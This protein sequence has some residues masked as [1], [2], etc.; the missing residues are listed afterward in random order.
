MSHGFT[1]DFKQW[2]E[3]F[4]VNVQNVPPDWRVFSK[5]KNKS[6][7]KQAVTDLHGRD[8][9]DFSFEDRPEDFIKIEPLNQAT[10]LP[11]FKIQDKLPSFDG[12]ILYG[13][14]F[15]VPEEEI[16]QALKKR[17]SE[18][19]KELKEVTAALKVAN[20]RAT[21][22][23]QKV[24]D[25][26]DKEY[27]R[28]IEKGLFDDKLFEYLFDSVN[29]KLESMGLLKRKTDGTLNRIGQKRLRTYISSR[30]D[31]AQSVGSLRKRKAQLQEELDETTESI[32]YKR[33]FAGVIEKAF[34]KK[35]KYPNHPHDITLQEWLIELSVDNYLR[36]RPSFPY[37]YVVYPESGS[38]F[39]TKLG[40]AL[41]SRYGVTAVRGLRKLE[42]PTIDT[43]SLA[44]NYSDKEW[45]RKKVQRMQQQLQ[46]TRGQIKN[47]GRDLKHLRPYV[48]N[49]EV[50][51]EVDVRPEHERSGLRNRRIL[52]VDDN[53]ASSGTLQATYHILKRIKPKSIHIYAPLWVNFSR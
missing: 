29:S 17:K 48:R 50:D 26:I 5:L 18:L 33:R 45:Q 11:N 12:Q 21:G 27:D 39:N 44:Q 3:G 37:D 41:A 23:T 52:L 40:E 6:V 14:K 53:I 34:L 10:Q 9:I 13:F 42:S 28:W 36:I 43:H 15:S 25:I 30:R 38:S 2:L 24:R 46:N 49:W 32:Q 22:M 7:A 35:V 31:N 4:G 16:S 20:S 19:Q 47:L 1:L 8:V 51:P